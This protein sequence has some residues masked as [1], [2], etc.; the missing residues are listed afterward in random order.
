IR[1]RLG[2]IHVALRRL[3]AAI[4]HDESRAAP[5]S[6]V[7]DRRPIPGRHVAGGVP[8]GRPGVSRDHATASA[9]VW[10]D[11]LVFGWRARSETNA[12]MSTTASASAIAG[13]IAS[14]KAWVKTA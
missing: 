5:Q 1:Q 14:T 7:A 4:E 13:R 9:T 12:A 6:S 10:R 8:G 2:Q 11:S 3:H